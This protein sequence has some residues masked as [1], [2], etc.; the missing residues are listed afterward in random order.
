MTPPSPATDSR[1]SVLLAHGWHP[2]TL[3][4]RQGGTVERWYGPARTDR[5]PPG[6]P[7]AAAWAAHSAAETHGL[8]GE[9]S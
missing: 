1:R 8:L 6:L 3:P 4:R 9:A 7:I 5:E 2:V